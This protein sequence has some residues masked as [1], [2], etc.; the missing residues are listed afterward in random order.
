MFVESSAL[1]AILLE[2]PE[3]K[4]FLRRLEARDRRVTSVVNAFEATL[5]VGRAIND[6]RTA[7]RLVQAFLANAKIDVLPF[8][9][10]CFGDAVEAFAR[11]GRGTSHPAK[12]NF[13]DCLSYA[14]AKHA[15]MPVL[16]KGRDFA[17]T[18]IE[19]A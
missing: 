1:V 17:L 5:A 9:V 4:D 2:E 16:F 7:G 12:L 19:K 6:Y 11:F 10:D 14:A 15:G 13:G 8:E 3:R 18:D